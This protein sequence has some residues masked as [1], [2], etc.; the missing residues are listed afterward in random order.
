MRQILVDRARRKRSR[1]RGG[2]RVRVAL[3][4]A[5]LAAARD[6]EEVLAVDQ[7]LAGLAAA[8][9]QA[10]ELGQ[11]R[12]F[13][14]LSIPEAA[15]AL[16]ISPRSADPL[17]AYA[18]AW[19]RRELD[20][21]GGGGPWTGFHQGKNLGWFGRGISHCLEG[22]PGGAI[23][24]GSAHHGPQGCC[25]GLPHD[26]GGR[27]ISDTPRREERTGTGGRPHQPADAAG[28]M[29]GRVVRIALSRLSAR[30]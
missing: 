6:A 18:R 29:P 3:D 10:A 7:A 5:N 1:K 23:R 9:P 21:S 13:D 25:R 11:L 30:R 20:R 4:E 26:G 2:D 14:D 22:N 27:S 28:S 15:E 12:Y 8:D 24:G 17:W 16:K 19:L